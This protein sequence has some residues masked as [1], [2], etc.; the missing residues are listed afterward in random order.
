MKI[1]NAIILSLSLFTYS[2]ENIVKVTYLKGLKKVTDTSSK[3]PSLLKDINYI[4]IANY[5]ESIF[6][7]EE[8]MSSSE[9]NLNKRFIGQGGGKGVY[10]K[11]NLTKE[12]FHQD[13]Y[14]NQI[15]LIDLGEKKW[16]L[17]KEKRLIN[18]FTCFKAISEEKYFSAFLNK[19]IILKHIAWYTPEI[20][21][22]F[23]P[24]V[25]NGL[26]GLV[27]SCQI[28]G[29]YFVADKIEFK[30]E[31]LEIKKPTKGIKIS[32]EDFDKKHKEEI[33]E[34]LKKRKG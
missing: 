25:F 31:K 28:G 17:T 30:K 11:N 32:F 12:Y 34:I 20:Q 14:K 9:I 19:E 3:K 13:D 5:T 4:L 1:L 26:P 10:Y 24:T 33:G 22:P 15:Y 7:Y 8:K 21:I 16:I 23:G 29:Y 18:N 6:K 27:I 2:Q